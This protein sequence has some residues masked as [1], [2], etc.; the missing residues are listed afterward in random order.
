MYVSV[1]CVRM[2]EV[3]GEK[4]RE[5]EACGGLFSKLWKGSAGVVDRVFRV[6]GAVEAQKKMLCRRASPL[7]FRLIY[8]LNIINNIIVIK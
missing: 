7:Y 2:C 1:L 8:N 6:R 3:E 5:R 4:E